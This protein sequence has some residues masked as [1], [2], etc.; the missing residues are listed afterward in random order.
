MTFQLYIPNIYTFLIL[1]TI[2]IFVSS[3]NIY[4]RNFPKPT[5]KMLKKYIE[6]HDD[7]QVIA[8]VNLHLMHA[9]ETQLVEDSKQ[10]LVEFFDL[11]IKKHNCNEAE[12]YLCLHRKF[13]PYLVGKMVDAKFP[14][15]LEPIINFIRKL[16]DDIICSENAKKT[17]SVIM[18]LIKIEAKYIDLGKDL[19]LTLLMLDLIGG[20]QAI[21]DLPTN[22]GSV[23]VGVMLGSI[24]IPMILSSVQLLNSKSVAHYN[25][26]CSSKI[27][28]FLKT[29]LFFL[30]A[31]FHPIILDTIQHKKMEKARKWAQNY[32]LNAPG[33]LKQ[34]RTLT[35]QLATFIKIELGIKSSFLMHSL[36]FLDA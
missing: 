19:G 8:E 2:E 15:C 4:N 22:F 25:L 34:C 26:K 30:L 27:K 3:F 31:P 21:I 35:R 17:L 10:T 32:N 24:F 13:D 36:L 6:N 18:A 9:I 33:I 23:I 28:T 5:Y 11:E 29:G 16:S 12:I 7:Q 1:P 14:G 20:T